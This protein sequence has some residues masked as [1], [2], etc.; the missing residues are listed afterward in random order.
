MVVSKGENCKESGCWTG[1]GRDGHFDRYTD[2]KFVIDYAN[3][4]STDIM[5]EFLIYK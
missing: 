3:N 4:Y 5:R 1:G 2:K